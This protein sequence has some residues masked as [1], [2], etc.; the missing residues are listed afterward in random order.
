[1][2][3]SNKAIP[4]RI[5]ITVLIAGIVGVIGEFI[6]N[7]NMNRLMDG[8]TEIT[9]THQ[10]NRS[11]MSDISGLLYR[12]QIL[13]SLHVISDDAE[14]MES[15]ALQASDVAAKIR[16]ELSE[17]GTRMKGDKREQ[18]Y[19]K[20]YSNFYSY[21]QNAEVAIEFSDEGSRTTAFYYVSDI[22]SPFVVKVNQSLDDLKALTDEEMTEAR[23]RMDHI[24]E[25]SSVTQIICVAGIIVSIVSC[26]FLCVKM[27]SRLS[28]SKNEL[29]DEVKRKTDALREHDEKLLR[30]QN[31]TI[32]GMATLIESRDGDTGSHVIRTSKYVEMLAK[33]AQKAGLHPLQLTDSY[34][35]LLVKAAPL[36]DIGK[37][38]VPDSILFKPGKLTPEEYD[39]I[40]NHAAEGGRIVR[41]AL[42]S[43]EEREYVDIAAQVAQYHHEK[44]DGTGYSAA[45]AGE[46]IPLCARIMAIADVFDALISK[47]CYKEAMGI[48]EAFDLIGELSGSH[49]DPELA[50]IFISLKSDIKEYLAS[51]AA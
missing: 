20:V 40:K 25:I 49:F 11:Y 51:Q 6:L 28:N 45:L 2:S 12:H 29:E 18:L 22:L 8:Y 17:L 38:S 42:G 34:I 4:V 27:T 47:R 9:E 16:M 36:H 37:I 41:Q 44:W 13:V 3:G 46:S 5:L 31:N 39:E 43:V 21:L 23:E 33:A 14:K 50:G 48:D 10:V 7:Y 1:M 32:M 26:C 15:Y 30:I 35:D 24:M 19:H